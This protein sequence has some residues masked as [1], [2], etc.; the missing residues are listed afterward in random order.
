MAYRPSQFLLSTLQATTALSLLCVAPAHAL[1]T[2]GQVVGGSATIA[3][4]G[5]QTTVTQSTQRGIINWQTFDI[6]SGEH[7]QFVQPSAASVTLNRVIGGQGASQILGNLTANGTV[8]LVN[9]QGMF[10]GPNASVNAGSFLATTSDIADDRF[11]AGDYRFDRPGDANAVIM[12]SGSITVAE[13]GLAA[14]VA[15]NVVNSGY[16]EARLGTV[17]LTSG[18][19]YTLDLYGDGLIN[20]EASAAIT[21]Q[22]V[23]NSGLIAAQGGKVLMTAAAAQ[24]V[25]NSLINMDGIIDATSIAERNGEIVIF[26]EGSN[27]V[28]DNDPTQKGQKQGASNVLVSGIL[29]ASGR[30]S[31]ERGGKITVSGDNVALLAGTVIDASGHS[32]LSGTTEGKLVSAVREGSAGGDIRI[33]GDYL[34]QGD[35]PTAR[36]LY[37]DSSALILND[38]LYTGD[39]GRTIFWSDGTTQFYGNVYARALGGQSV[40]QLTWHASQGGN[41]GDGGFVETSGHE[42][43][44]AGG[45]VDL[46]ASNGKRGT[47]F[48]DPTNITI[49][50]NFDPSFVSTDSSIN[51]AASLKLWLD[52]SDTSRVTLTYSTDGLSGATATGSSGSNTITTSVNVASN[53]AVGARIRL[54]SAGAVT[55]AATMGA[56]TYTITSIAGTTITLA[57]NLTQ[58]YAG[59]TL[60][61]GLV[62]QL[63]DR[64]GLANNAT[65]ATAANMPLWISN[66]QNGLGTSRFDGTNDYLNVQ[67]SSA[68][69]PAYITI[70]TVFNT[71]DTARNQRI[72]AKTESGGY[73]LSLNQGVE[74][75]SGLCALVNAGNIYYAASTSSPS[76]VA[77]TAYQ[78][79]AVYSGSSVSLSLNGIQS[80]STPASGNIHYSFN[81]SL[82]I[83][84]EP[85]AAST[86]TGQYFVGTIPE[87]L[88]YGVALTATPRSLVEQYQSAKW[89][90]AL[91]PP[92]TGATE[93]AKAM[94]SDGYSAFTTRYLERLSQSADISLQ[95]TNNITLDLKGDTLALASDRNF[96]LTTTSGNISSA[97]AGTITTTRT[98]SGGNITMTAGGTGTI[99]V[100]NLTLNANNGGSI[101][102]TSSGA[103]TLGTMTAGSILAR[104]TGA[105]SDLTIAAGRVL[106]ASSTGNAITLASGRNFI[107]NAGSGALSTPSGRWLVYST[108][109]ASDTI[110]SLSNGFRRFSCTYGGSCPSFPASGNGFLYSYTPTLTATPSA[111]SITYG[112]TAPGLSGYAYT[113]SGYLGS[114]SGSDSISGS[115]TGTTPYSQGSNV[116]TYAVNYASGSLSSSLGYG[117]SYANNA[118]ALTVNQKTLTASLTGTVSKKYDGTNTATLGSGNYVLSGVYGSDDVSLNNP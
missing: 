99:D 40:D 23:S 56:D 80:A 29:D 44:D 34:G 38:A 76:L 106:T 47:Y 113:L 33:G 8:M 19:S 89:G 64:S 58:N 110:G 31:G 73:Q 26:A 12:N 52:A 91:T 32:G 1:P 5:S 17:Q 72:V 69:T 61:R 50:G 105:S 18:D 118:T 107:N 92:G 45:Y 60:Y 97:S 84:A 13:G 100:S 109:P 16:I 24:E 6:G 41:A 63:A 25:V 51:L 81:N 74:C 103:M 20:L 93:A 83:G 30:R 88:V 43:L 49:Y 71:Q 10:I 98:G 112:D 42:H 79:S 48:L 90:V 85:G 55:T 65:Q 62:S 117:F 116:G 46:T 22:L 78:T 66:G 53:L 21:S 15:P 54:G 67:H 14:F 77:N 11:M 37:V 2:G 101:T 70:T 94:A 115:L 35:T 75:G 36:N 9:S 87:A 7:V 96:S 104:T 108:N 27:A 111:L 68:V 57:E 59:S 39:A 95:A 3:S 28:K 86:P 82:L 4:S 114:D 102:L